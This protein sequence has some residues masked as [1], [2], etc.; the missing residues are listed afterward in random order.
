MGGP[1]SVRQWVQAGLGQGDYTHLTGAGYRMTGDVLFEELMAQYNRFLSDPRRRK[2]QSIKMDNRERILAIVRKVSEQTA[3]SRS[4]MNRCSTPGFWIR[5]R[6]RTWWRNWSGEFGIKIPDS[7][8]NPRKFESIAEIQATS[9][10][11]CSWWRRSKASGPI[12]RRALSPTPN[13]P[14]AWTANQDWILDVSG[15]EERRY[16]APDE[17]V[18]TMGVAAACA[19]RNGEPIG[20]ILVSSGSSERRFPGP[21]SA[22]AHAL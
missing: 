11:G 13:W 17:T 12:C 3:A 18:V 15:I 21:A 19:A 10:A 8:L 16:A 14:R 22:I 4:P 7:D 20:M 1:G 2:S 6:C 9:R 5:S